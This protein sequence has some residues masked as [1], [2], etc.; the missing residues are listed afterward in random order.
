MIALVSLLVFRSQLLDFSKDK[1]GFY[2]AFASQ[3][4][5]QAMQWLRENTEPDVRV[6]N[7]PGTAFDNSHEGDWVP[8]ISER[9]SVYYR[10]QP[11]FQGNEASLAEQERLRAFWQ[12]PANLANAELL[13][14]AGH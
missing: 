13:R 3:D 7:F 11:F 14:Q 10:W 2:G 1:I 8:V 4:D 6:L 12:D 9:D 5:V